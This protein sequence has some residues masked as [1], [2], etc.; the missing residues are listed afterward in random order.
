MAIAA[1]AAAM[2]AVAPAPA[3]TP[4][5]MLAAGTVAPE[6]MKAWN[7]MGEGAQMSRGGRPRS[8]QGWPQ[9]ER[10]RVGGCDSGRGKSSVVVQALYRPLYFQ[11]MIFREFPSISHSPHDVGL[12]LLHTSSRDVL[13]RPVDDE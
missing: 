1:A 7:K 9:S 10:I 13:I 12:T 11:I 6:E 4:A 3:A 5:V 2:L 8:F